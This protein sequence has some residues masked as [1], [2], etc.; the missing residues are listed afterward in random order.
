MIMKKKRTISV[1]INRIFRSFFLLILP[2]TVVWEVRADYPIFF[3]RYTADPTG[4]VHNDRLYLYCSHD[5]YEPGTRYIMN[6]VTCIST[7]D[8]K[9]WTDHGEI[10]HAKDSK[11][12]AKLTWAPHVVY[13]N[14]KF[15]LYY[16]D[17]MECIGVAV[18][19]SPTGPFVDANN[20][21]LVNKNT[22]GVGR[23][24][25]Q[26]GMWCFDPGVLID[27]DGQ[28]Y[29]Y[30]GGSAE[31]NSRVIKLKE[32]MV[33][34]EGPAI[35]LN[36]PGFFEAAFMHKYNGK[37]YLSYAGHHFGTPANIEYVVS[38]DP[39]TG[40]DNP[41]L[42]MK[43]PPVNDDFNNHHSIFEFNGDWY[44]AY[45]NR[46]LAHDNGM[47][48]KTAREFM[49]SIAIDRLNHNP[50]GTIKEVMPTAAGLKQIKYIN[51]YIL[52]E[53][54]TMA[55]SF[56]GINT[57]DHKGGRHVNEIRNNSWILVC[58]V[59]FGRNGAK[60]VEMNVASATV[61]GL[62]EL[63]LDSPEG[64]IIGRVRVGNTGGWENWTTRTA[65]LTSSLNGIH[66]LYFVFRGD[67]GVLMTFDHWKFSDNILINK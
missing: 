46:Q 15:Y 34:V 22:P 61:G 52:N 35:A 47:P 37:Y 11:W 55:R 25:G 6:D 3:Q 1:L 31:M 14:E 13:R 41:G 7:D 20:A 26:W 43:N 40:F 29:M 45:H 67:V 63:R 53:A 9:N 30:F 18:S 59:D 50:D 48:D 32:N 33:E 39:I 58:G 27:D 16:G 51:P 64:E 57:A 65:N 8:M 10:F 44:I 36:T 42:A 66:D 2:V 54:E 56:G 38:N 28:A 19:D 17:G 21:P 60:S 12:G 4:M 62:I 49:R 24:G 5:R 23:G